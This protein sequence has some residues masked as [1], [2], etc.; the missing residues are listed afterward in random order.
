M[1][2]MMPKWNFSWKTWLR[3]SNSCQIRN[4]SKFSHGPVP[5]LFIC[6]TVPAPSPEELFPQMK[7]LGRGKL[8]RLYSTVLTRSLS[9]SPTALNNY[10]Q[11]YFNHLQQDTF[12]PN[13]DVCY[14]DWLL[15]SRAVFTSSISSARYNDGRM[16]AGIIIN[17][18][19]SSRKLGRFGKF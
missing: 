9:G 19:V 5:H 1:S 2:A 15:R 16:N 18:E 8:P 6:R 17:L 3:H 11:I 13:N 12:L 10:I 7:I 4:I 14:I